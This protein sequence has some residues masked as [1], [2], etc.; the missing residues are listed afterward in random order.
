MLPSQK[1]LL[2][3]RACASDGP[4]EE[5]DGGAE[6]HDDVQSRS[7]PRHLRDEADGGRPDEETEVPGGGDGGQGRAGGYLFAVAGGA[8]GRGED[9]GEPGPGCGEPGERENRLGDEEREPE[10]WLVR[11]GETEWSKSGQHT[12]VTDLPL[13]EAGIEAALTLSGLLSGVRFDLVLSSPMVR[14]RRTAELANVEGVRIE[15]DLVEWNYGDYEGRTR[16]DIQSERPGWSV[17][18]QGAPG[19]ES[20][21][22][23]SARVDRVIA[24]CRSS[25]GRSLL[26]AHGHVLRGLAAR[27]IDQPIDVGAHLRILLG[28]DAFAADGVFVRQRADVELQRQFQAAQ[29]VDEKEAFK[30]FSPRRLRNTYCGHNVGFRFAI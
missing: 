1:P 17:W 22:V 26:F 3:F 2:A 9:D 27:W 11:H 30:F 8:Q 16:N 28:V 5:D 23:L 21:E 15:D 10:V 4:G 25:G 24:T 29:E 14:A 6:G 19:G 13:T 18:T 20:P 7:E 12:G